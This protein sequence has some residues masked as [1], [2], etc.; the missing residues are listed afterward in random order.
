MA[1]AQRLFA[2]LGYDGVS[3]NLLARETGLDV[4][5]VYHYFRSKLALFSAVASA[6]AQ[7]YV[8]QF[9]AH[10]LTTAGI[11]A[12]LHAYLDA[13]RIMYAENPEAMRFLAVASREA[14]VARHRAREAPA[15]PYDEAIAPVRDLF[16]TVLSD[17]IRSGELPPGLDAG[18]LGALFD[19]LGRIVPNTVLLHPDDVAGVIDGLALLIDG[20]FFPRKPE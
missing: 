16:N 4:A 5:A 2:D 10:V 6:A 9:E 18:S 19:G 15:L 1:T 12:R 3:M 17:A 14:D 8:E 20:Q 11:T 7:R 13:Y